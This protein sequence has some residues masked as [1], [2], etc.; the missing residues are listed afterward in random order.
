MFRIQQTND[1]GI[2]TNLK[3]IGTIFIGTCKKFKRT[4]EESL[5]VP[6]YRT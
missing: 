6:F 3:K 2:F 4:F 5:K 1:S